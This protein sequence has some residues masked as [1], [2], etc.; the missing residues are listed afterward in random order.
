MTSLRN[1]QS[2]RERLDWKL[3][4]MGPVTLY[5]RRTYLDEDCAELGR[6]GYDIVRFDCRRWE[7]MADFHR[8]VAE[9]FS[10]PDYYGANGA[11]FR[12]CLRDLDLSI[13]SEGGLAIVFDDFDAFPGAEA[14]Q[15]VL[16]T[17]AAESR[18]FL[19]IGLRLLCLVHTSDG[20]ARFEP[21]G[22]W[23]PMWNRRE[24]LDS[25]R[26]TR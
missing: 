12:D 3:L 4:Q 19:V 10:F 9:R 5:W 15:G 22:G 23:P 17:I 14:G 21:V 24:F 8:E 7:T 18:V 2:T 13:P 11:A 25:S 26:R 20:D 6:L 16:D 1:D